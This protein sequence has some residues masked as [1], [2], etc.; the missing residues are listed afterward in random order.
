MPRHSDNVQMQS[1]Q[2]TKKP[3]S[4]FHSSFQSERVT[5]K[6]EAKAFRIR[7]ENWRKFD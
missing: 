2:R 1:L 4:Q 6:K 5:E 3:I 7:K